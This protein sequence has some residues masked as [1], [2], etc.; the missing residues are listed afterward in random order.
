MLLNGSVEELKNHYNGLSKKYG[1]EVLPPYT[2]IST[3]G[4][5]HMRKKRVK[6]AIKVFEYYITVYPEAVSGRF[7]LI[8]AYL[9]DGQIDKAKET[10]KKVL[11]LDPGNKRAREWLDSLKK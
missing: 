4:W 2:I 10:L 6:E 5:Q 11:T 9:D 1:F 8:Q 3:V 7:L